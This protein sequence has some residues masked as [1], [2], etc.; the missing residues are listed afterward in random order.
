MYSPSLAKAWA[1]ARERTDASEALDLPTPYPL[2]RE[3]IDHP[4]KFKVISC[5]RQVGKT[6]L[7]ALDS[8]Q[9][10]KDGERKLYTSTSQKQTD[11]FWEYVK[12]F[13]N[14]LNPYKHESRRIM[15]L[16]NGL[17]D[18]QTASAP[19]M[20]RSGHYH[21][22]DFDECAYLDARVWSQV[23]VPMLLR[24]D[25]SAS[26][27]STPKRRNWF[28]LHFNKAQS[29]Q[30]SGN[31]DWAVWNFSTLENPYLA[32]AA[33]KRL[34]E[35]MTDADYQQ[36]I[37]AKFLEGQGA[38]FRYVDARCTL[39][40]REPYAGQFV[41][42][43]DQGQA[44]DYFV[45]LVMDTES[46]EV[47]AYD[48]FRQVDWNT[49]RNRLKTLYEAWKP[50]TIVMESNMGQVDPNIE[51]LQAESLPIQVFHTT[52]VTKPPLIESLVLAFDRDETRCLDD[53][54]IKGELMA[55]ERKVTTTGRSQYSAP[56]GLHD[57]CVIAY[58]L[59]WHGVQNQYTMD[60][61]LA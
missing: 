53:P 3:I 1:R 27:W 11:Q 50:Q 60:Y 55:Y 46:R 9:R 19:D 10:L 56:A 31:P 36:E 17:L 42:G 8:R 24:Y 38:V 41:F 21:H 23:G 2:Q 12:Q 6:L 58:A 49:A 15:R 47:V 13:T 28:F 44:K 29:E 35:N 20:L 25:G 52:G 22:I 39:A 37:L 61:F 5:G 26:F 48:R 57:D 59:A 16:G 45:I 30:K 40:P 7:C 18:V 33:L 34:T 4:A 43:V 54:I 51:M 14:D 32:E